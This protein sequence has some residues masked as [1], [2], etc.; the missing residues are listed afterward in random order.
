MSARSHTPLE[1]E[2]VLWLNTSN[3]ARFLDVVYVTF[4]KYM[5]MYHI[6]SRTFLGKGRFTYYRLDHLARLKSATKEELVALE[7]DLLTIEDLC[8]RDTQTAP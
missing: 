3:G 8:V 1:R 5:K 2:G 4:T 6:P 7:D